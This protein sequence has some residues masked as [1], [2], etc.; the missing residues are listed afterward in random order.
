MGNTVRANWSTYSAGS[1]VD[2]PMVGYEGGRNRVMRYM[3]ETENNGASHIYIELTNIDFYGGS[4]KQDINWYIGTDADS[5]KN[6]GVGSVS[7]G[8]VVFNSDYS[9]AEVDADVLLLPNT[10]YY[11]WLFPSVSTYSCYEFSRADTDD[12][13]NTSGGAGLVYIK[14]GSEVKRYQAY[15]KRSSGWK[16]LLPHKKNVSAWDLLTG[17]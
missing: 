14:R 11:F 4:I 9:V 13:L 16:L 7:M 8:T 10:T 12:T 17:G 3:F 5:H 1:E 15:V 6:A 2:S